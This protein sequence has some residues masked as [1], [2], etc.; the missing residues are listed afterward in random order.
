M[1]IS[2]IIPTFNRAETLAKTVARLN[3]QGVIGTEIIVVDDGSDKRNLEMLAKISGVRLFCQR[4]GGPAA[5]RN[6]G[7]RKARG[8]V[9]VFLNDDV[10]V[11][12]NFLIT[13]ARFHTKETDLNVGLMGPL[14]EGARSLS[15]AME[16]LV[17]RSNQHFSYRLAV[18]QMVPWYYFWTCN[19]SIKKA[20]LLENGLLFDDAF[21]TAAWEDIEFAYRA[22]LK[23]LRLFYDKSLV[24]YHHHE[25]GFDEVLARFYSHGRGLYYLGKKLPD[26]FLPPLAKTG[27]RT[28]FKFLFVLTGFFEW[29]HLLVARL[30][31]QRRVSN[32]WMQTLVLSEK[33]RGFNYEDRK[34]R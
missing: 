19:V 7:I 26:N 5:A 4:H 28:L 18:G 12:K 10:W 1:K 15:P 32:F 30:R 8:E 33:I 24:V 17:Q 27:I 14:R 22:K 29:R 3:Q 21:P 34:V 2:V 20:F 23:G 9:L 13:H 6:L 25:F 11:E 31:R 16:W